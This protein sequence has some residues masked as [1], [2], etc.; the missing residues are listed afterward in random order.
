MSPC[1][2][3]LPLEGPTPSV[4]KGDR[5]C[6]DGE[7][8]TT[9]SPGDRAVVPFQISCGACDPLPARPH[10]Q[11][12]RPS[13]NV[14]LRLGV[15]AA[16]VG[17]LLADLVVVPHADAMLVPVPHGI[18][19]VAIASASDNIPDAWRTVGPQLAANPGPSAGCRRRRRTQRDRAV[20]RRSRRCPERRARHL[21]RPPTGPPRHRGRYVPSSSTARHHAR[22]GLSPSQWMRVAL[23]RACAARSTAPPSTAPARARPSTSRIPAFRCSPCTR[24]A[25]RCTLA[26]PRSPGHT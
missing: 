12:R 15:M 7:R 2:G 5:G 17:R 8:V 26:G 23:P 20:C 4:T 11:L 9:V 25:A 19:P 14:D 13:S 21:P 10:R 6:G 1:S 16:P 18:D 3:P 22:P 24:G